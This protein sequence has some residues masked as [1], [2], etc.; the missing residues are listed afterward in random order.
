M[1]IY[2]CISSVNDR[3][4]INKKV[5]IFP[6]PPISTIQKNDTNM[7]IYTEIDI[8]KLYIPVCARYCSFKNLSKFHV[9]DIFYVT[10]FY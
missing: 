2:T 1:Y 6:I 10:I 5:L 8:D 7:S 4:H 9:T 3:N